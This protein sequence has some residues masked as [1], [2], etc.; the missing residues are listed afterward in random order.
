MGSLYILIA[1]FL[2]S[3]VGIVVRL[4]GVSTHILI[5]CSIVV[6]LVIQG[7]LLTQKKYRKDIPG[8]RDLKYP[9]IL[10]AV[11]LLNT[12]SYYYAYRNTT[13]ANAVLTHYIAPILVAL[14]APM[15]LKEKI[16]KRIFFVI[17]IASAGLWIMLGGFSFK[18]AQAAGIMAGLLS[19]IAYAVIVI[20]LR[21]YSPHFNPLVL[22]FFTNLF[23]AIMLVPF[24]REVPL[25]GV[26]IYLFMGTVHSTIAPVLYYKGLQY[27]TANRSAVL[28]YLEPVSAIALGMLLLNEVPGVNSIIGGVLIMI[29]GYLTLTTAKV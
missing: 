24:V 15:I 19:G 12:F 13:V 28:G 5:F 18:E 17:I 9:L 1:I 16:T 2:W 23:I 10:G 22:S 29:S 4:S 8:I 3:S 25:K 6:S 27:V 7:L 11:S 14:L 20:F 21:L 26:W